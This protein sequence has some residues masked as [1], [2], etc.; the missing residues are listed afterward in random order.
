VLA[1]GEESCARSF[2]NLADASVI[3]VEDVGVADVIGAARVVISEAALSRLVE[4][5]APSGERRRG[6]GPPSTGA[7]Q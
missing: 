5:A 2:R 7:S 6:A 1:D 4:K 3:H